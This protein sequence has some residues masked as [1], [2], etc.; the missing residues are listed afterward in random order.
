M[1]KILSGIVIGSLVLSMVGCTSKEQPQEQVYT[2]KYVDSEGNVTKKQVSEEEYNKE[3]E[4]AKKA[5][6]KVTT[7]TKT[8]NE[9][10]SV[11]QNK[12]DNK[13]DDRNKDEKV[14]NEEP[15]DKENVKLDEPSEFYYCDKCGK[16]VSNENKEYFPYCYN[17]YIRIKQQIE[18]MNK[19]DEE[20]VK[21][22]EP[23]EQEDE[24]P[25]PKYDYYCKECGNGVYKE[26]S[27]VYPYCVSCYKN[28]ANRDNENNNKEL[29]S[30]PE[31]YEDDN[32][33]VTSDSEIHEYR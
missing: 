22:D 9:E 11:E 33:E 32:E 7:Q 8:T 23:S 5:G 28:K 31:I 2:I 20:D 21:L 13:S 25:A 30:D 24:E 14:K 17:C 26:D 18:N 19:E 12:V 15:K 16:S 1:K 6:K 27:G 4:E 3:V 29:V 10:Q